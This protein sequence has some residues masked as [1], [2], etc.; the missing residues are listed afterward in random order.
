MSL[1]N[2]QDS[3]DISVFELA[4]LPSCQT[5]ATVLSFVFCAL[6]LHLSPLLPYLVFLFCCS[7]VYP[8]STPYVHTLRVACR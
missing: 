5:G 8:L 4:L 1:A 6:N 2:V 7:R 3:P